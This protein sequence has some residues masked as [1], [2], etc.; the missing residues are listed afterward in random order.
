MM[1]QSKNATEFAEK[2]TSEEEHTKSFGS[3]LSI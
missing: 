1:L 2:N 3:T